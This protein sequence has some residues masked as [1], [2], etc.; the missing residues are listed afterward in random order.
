MVEKS[1]DGCEWVGPFS[2]NELPAKKSELSE[3]DFE[4]LQKTANWIDENIS[5]VVEKAP[6]RNEAVCPFVPTAQ[7]KGTV[8]LMVARSLQNSGMEGL[9]ELVCQLADLYESLSPTRKD[10]AYLFKSLVVVFPE[11]EGQLIYD[12]GHSSNW[13]KGEL[14][15]RGIELGDFFPTHPWPT[16]W[17]ETFHAQRS[18]FSAFV[19]RPF[20]EADWESV[21]MIPRYRKTYLEQFGSAPDRHKNQCPTHRFRKAVIYYKALLR[22]FLKPPKRRARR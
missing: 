22:D 11:V 1:L 2:A 9:S 20:V 8:Y 17:D 7:E 12:T 10:S 13:V 18:P 3:E 15:K 6:G 16:S 19:L 5:L 21:S 4:L 14:L